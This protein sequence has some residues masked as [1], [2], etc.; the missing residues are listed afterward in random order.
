MHYLIDGYNLLFRLL[1]QK[2]QSLEKKREALIAL[3]DRELSVIKG[4]VSIIFDSSEEIRE[5]AQSVKRKNLEVIYAPKGKTADEY[6]LELVE[7]RK[8]PKVLVVVSSDSGL[9][10]QCKYLEAQIQTIEEFFAFLAKKT[11]K[12]TEGKPQYRESQGEINRLIK[13]FEK[14]LKSD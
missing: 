11:K 5:F 6:I 13:I 3:L 12:T 1:D 9:T 14:R 10:K 7:Q 8:N 4:H 2:S